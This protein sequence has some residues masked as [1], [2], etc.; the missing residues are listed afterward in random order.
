MMNNN[1]YLIYC[2]ISKVLTLESMTS[3]IMNKLLILASDCGKSES[4]SGAFQKYYN[5]KFIDGPY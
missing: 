3:N 1:F 4:L 5:V 2:N